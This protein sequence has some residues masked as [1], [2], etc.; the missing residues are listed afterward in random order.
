[1]TGNNLGKN[2]AKLVR[3][4]N[5]SK[6]VCVAFYADSGSSPETYNHANLLINKLIR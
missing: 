3:P 4:P 2:T 6:S 1:M 5:G